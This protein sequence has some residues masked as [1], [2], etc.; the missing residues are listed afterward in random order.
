VVVD[1]GHIL[2][3][4]GRDLA[5][6]GVDQDIL[7]LGLESLDEVLLAMVALVLAHALNWRG[8]PEKLLVGGNGGLDFDGGHVVCS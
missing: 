2:F 7:V 6:V 5:S 4:L 1:S 3:G 8:E